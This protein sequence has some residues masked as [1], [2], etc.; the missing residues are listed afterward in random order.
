MSPLV[1]ADLTG[2]A[3]MELGT[4]SYYIPHSSDHAEI[5]NSS[6][7]CIVYFGVLGD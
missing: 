4:S 2:N 5:R 6:D 7:H 1:T 3:R